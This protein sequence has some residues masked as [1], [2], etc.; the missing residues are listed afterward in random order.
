VPYRESVPGS[1]RQYPFDV[2][3]IYVWEYDR[4]VNMTTTVAW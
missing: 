4:V 2:G 1:I 3:D